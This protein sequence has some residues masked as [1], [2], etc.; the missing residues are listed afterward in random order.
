MGINKFFLIFNIKWLRM[1][2][3][4]KL[5]ILR[6]E[7]TKNKKKTLLKIKKYLW[8]YFLSFCEFYL[9]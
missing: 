4:I 7:N 3:I 5:F 2:F 6:I 1:I 9:Y 8:N